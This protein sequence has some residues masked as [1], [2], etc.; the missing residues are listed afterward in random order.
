MQVSV[1]TVAISAVVRKA[2]AG[3][4]ITDLYKKDPKVLRQ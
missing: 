3:W 4:L 2:L 1:P